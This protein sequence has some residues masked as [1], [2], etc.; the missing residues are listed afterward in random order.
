MRLTVAADGK[1]ASGD[2]RRP[3]E[4]MKAR[5]QRDRWPDHADYVPDPWPGTV[6]ESST[7]LNPD[8]LGKG[9]AVPAGSPPPRT[10]GGPV[11]VFGG[12]FRLR[13]GP[14]RPGTA[15]VEGRGSGALGSRAVPAGI[16]V[17]T[18]SNWSQV[19]TQ[20]SAAA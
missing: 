12:G 2:L 18:P 17:R 19:V 7:D 11:G 3:V 8:G 4:F 6:R 14:P 10:R 9:Y 5:A 13:A 1:S 20:G 16:A 15:G